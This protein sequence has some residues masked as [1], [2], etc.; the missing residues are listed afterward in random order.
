MCVTVLE[1]LFQA[2]KEVFYSLYRYSAPLILD[3]KLLVSK[4]AI[5]E[6][7]EIDHNEIDFKESEEIMF[8]ERIF[9][10]K[11]NVVSRLITIIYN[12]D[13]ISFY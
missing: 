7:D 9:F 3:V 6:F 13:N 11:V 5:D 2:L 1:N 10:G 8:D 12:D 4:I